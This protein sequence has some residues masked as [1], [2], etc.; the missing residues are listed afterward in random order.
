VV[1]AFGHPNVTQAKGRL[2]LT[3]CST[4]ITGSGWVRMDI[5]TLSAV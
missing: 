3:F 5:E 2:S 4:A 1:L